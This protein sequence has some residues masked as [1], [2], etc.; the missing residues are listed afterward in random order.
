VPAQPVAVASPL[1]SE[2]RRAISPPLYFDNL[3][4]TPVDPRVLEAMLPYFTEH[5]GNASSKGHPYGWA[6]A[7][8]VESARQQVA[9]LIGASAREIIFT[10]GAT[11]ANNLAIKGAAAFYRDRGNHIVTCV[12]EHPAVLD[13]CSSLESVGYRVSRVGVDRQGRIDLDELR[14]VVE[15]GTILVSVMVANNEIGTIQPMREIA[16]LAREHGALMHCDAAQAAGKIPLD[17][18][19]LGADLISIS[20]HKMYGPKGKGAL[21]VR[22]RNPRVRLQAQIEGGG[23]ERGLRSGTLDVPGIVGLGAACALARSEMEEEGAR[24]TELRDYLHEGLA[25][26]LQ[27]VHLNG[28]PEHR[29]PGC[30]NLRLGDVDGSQLLVGLRDHV[31]LSSGSAC[32][33]GTSEPSHVLRAIGVTDVE[34]F[35]SVRLGLGRFTTRQDVDTVIERVVEEFERLEK[36]ATT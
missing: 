13:C 18:D 36:F 25:Q 19:E 1:V 35:A 23:Q 32:A 3:A 28:H 31:A 15:D 29:L 27:D 16:A 33:S 4:T 7:A 30:L 20:A 9:L 34:A 12:T 17:I 2:P 10:S 21:F 5:F 22:A 6:A 8:A 14:D 24:T 26:R 11:E